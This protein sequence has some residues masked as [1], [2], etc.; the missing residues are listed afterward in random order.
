MTRTSV[1]VVGGSLNG[2]SLAL[3]LARRRV[4]CTVVERHPATTVQYKFAGISP[5]SMEIYRGAGIEQ[6]IRERRTGDQKGGEIARARSLADPDVRFL[7]KPW[8]DMSDLSAASAET[9]DQD[10]L[11]PILRAHA[12]RL[13]AD[14]RFHTELV[15]FTQ[16]EHA[17]LAR[18]R[19]LGTGRED[20]VEA[21]YLVAADGIGGRTRESL[22]IERTGPGVLQHWMNLIFDTDLEP[23]L[24]GR[25]FTSCFVTDLNA[26]VT[27]R[28]DHW[29]LALQYRPERG[30]SPE[31][32]DAARTAELVRR[33]AG[34]SDVRAEL[35]DARAWDV[36]AWLAERFREGRAFLLGDAAHS[37]PPTGA[38][39]GNTGIHD[40]H[41]LAWKLELVLGRAAR[42]GLLESYQIERRYV[43]EHSL[44]QALARLA[45]WFEDPSK[46]LPAPVPIVDDAAVIFGYVYP[47]G[48]LVADAAAS[49]AFENPHEPTGRPGSRAPHFMIEHAG[50]F[51]PVHDCFGAGFVLL[52]GAAG[53]RW[54][55]A[56]ANAD[57]R[58][59]AS[60]RCLP[61]GP[62]GHAA[63]RRFEEVY[64][65]EADGAVLVRPDGHIAWRAQRAARD[66]EAELAGALEAVHLCSR[67]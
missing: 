5:R 41:N 66:P 48:A 40:G 58:F 19:D 4:G 37:M 50:S 56:A 16:D 54:S 24:K 7:G 1:L 23:F 18:V 10:R 57:R 29:L 35:F 46:R 42:P 49:A 65:V 60:I 53:Q 44:A 13:G 36:T 20:V 3:F 63:A 11:E 34:R 33:A 52:T 30:E 39:G 12:E 22:G 55:E 32:F 6:E 51:V 47:G 8:S 61:A 25:R 14:V 38:F 64:H 67:D 27:P 45:A 28:E 21:D 15:S 17:V 62:R 43:A 59:A 31:G 9:C 26:T 2:L